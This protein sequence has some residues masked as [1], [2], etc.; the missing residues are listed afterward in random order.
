ML[1]TP[2]SAEGL[3]SPEE[4]LRLESAKGNRAKPNKTF[5]FQQTTAQIFATTEVPS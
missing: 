1:K 3:H 2:E 4:K 5:M